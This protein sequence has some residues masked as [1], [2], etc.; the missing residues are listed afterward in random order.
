MV[1]EMQLFGKNRVCR[2][3]CYFLKINTDTIKVHKRQTEGMVLFFLIFSLW[4]I[5]CD[6][7]E[8][9]QAFRSNLSR[10]KNFNFFHLSHGYGVSTRNSNR[11]FPSEKKVTNRIRYF[12]CITFLM[13]PSLMPLT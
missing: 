10:L 2:S 11:A 5:V 6:E 1:V 8:G 9:K 4:E 13:P 3:F 12:H 7:E